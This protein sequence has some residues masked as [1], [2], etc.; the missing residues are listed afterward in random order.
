VGVGAFGQWVFGGLNPHARKLRYQFT[1]GKEANTRAR[2]TCE[3]GVVAARQRAGREGRHLD[4]VWGGPRQTHGPA[5][6]LG[7]GE[8]GGIEE[9]LGRRQRAREVE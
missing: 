7:G 3:I 5:Q 9:G 1:S 2:P 4:V 8:G 6:Q